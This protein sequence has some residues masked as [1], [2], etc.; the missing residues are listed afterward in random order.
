[1]RATG[2]RGEL[3]VAEILIGKGF[4]VSLPLDETQFDLVAT[5]GEKSFR[6]QVKCTSGP[7]NDWRRTHRYNFNITR[8]NS[9]RKAYT[10]NDCDF[11]I[12]I[13][14]DTRRFWVIPIEDIK[15]SSLKIAAASKSKY[16]KYE[17]RWDLIG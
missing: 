4:H 1:M 2:T 7:A 10:F 8:G 3:L 5:S 13:A 9:T 14:L 6:L 15:T 12:C 11:L 17:G 16:S